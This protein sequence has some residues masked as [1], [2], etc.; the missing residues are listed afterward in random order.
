MS[1]AKSFKSTLFACYRGYIV[2]GIINNISPLF[3]VIYQDQFG[4]SYSKLSTLI[5]LNFVTQI[6]VDVLCVKFVDKI[7]YRAAAIVAHACS[8]V[9]LIGLGVLPMIMPSAFLG[10][11]IATVINA[12]GGGVIEVIISPIIDSI[13][14]DEQNGQM[15]LLHSFYCWGQ[16]GVVLIT[17]AAVKIIG[18]ELWWILPI[19]WALIPLFN[20][21]KFAKVP[22]NPT[23]SDEERTPILTLFKSKLFVILMILMICAGAS[24]LA[25]SQWSSLFAEKGLGVS[26]IMGDLLGP[27]MFAILMGTGRALYG[28]FSS[29]LNLHRV[30]VCSGVLCILCYLGAALFTSPI[31]SLLSCALCGLSVAVMWPGVFSSSSQMFPAGGTAMFGILA[32]CGDIG[33]TSGPAI[34]GAI[35]EVASGIYGDAIGLKVSMLAAAIFPLILLIA[36][37]LFKKLSLQKKEPALN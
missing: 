6:I 19:M 24:E 12:I 11:G 33:C 37:Y 23:I 27:C 35:S 31:L 3:F 21:I 1:A 8:V 22:L 2:Q 34:A 18:S 13:P 14:S 20:M 36:L 5:M 30:L 16:V 15:S 9:G 28:I 7:G 17:T 10:L 32:V 26:K 29:R 25:M 4:L